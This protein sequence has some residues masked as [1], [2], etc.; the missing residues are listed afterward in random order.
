MSLTQANKV[1]YLKLYN[2]DDE[3]LLE[4]TFDIEKSFG[5]KFG[6]QDFADVNTY[7]ELCDM[8]IA[9]FDEFEDVPDS[10]T[11]QAFYKLRAAIASALAI[12]ESNI[13]ADTKLETLI[14]AHRRPGIVKNVN[15]NLGIKILCLKPSTWYVNLVLLFS[16]LCLVAFFFSWKIAVSGII[17]NIAIWN[18]GR[19]FGMEFENETLAEFAEVIARDHYSDSRQ[20]EKTVNKAEVKFFL[21]ERI[22]ALFGVDEAALTKD[23]KFI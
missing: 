15:G 14:P 20:E 11:E 17:L 22:A 7:G 9:K 21:D 19:R 1:S 2:I 18:L 5:I 6:D 4:F 3:A 13:N 8:I 12:S 23:S 16:I 10:T